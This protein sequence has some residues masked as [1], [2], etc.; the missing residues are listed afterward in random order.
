M[1]ITRLSFNVGTGL[2]LLVL[3][4][5]VWRAGASIPPSFL[6][7]AFGTGYLPMLAGAGLTI[8]ACILIVEAVREGDGPDALVI[9][10]RLVR[11]ALTTLALATFIANLTLDL[12]PFYPAAALLIFVVAAGLGEQTPKAIAIAL[13]CAVVATLAAWLVF[14]QIFVV[15]IG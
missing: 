3:G 2:A 10:R 13:A 12:V 14:T 1:R 5:F 7:T 11:P 8:L 15:L 4:A 9:D 6:D